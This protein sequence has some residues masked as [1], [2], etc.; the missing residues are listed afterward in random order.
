VGWVFWVFHGC[1][2]TA[3]IAMIATTAASV[4]YNTRVWLPGVPESY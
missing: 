2:T 1:H 4:M 3:T